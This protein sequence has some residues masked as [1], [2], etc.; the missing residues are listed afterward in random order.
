MHDQAH[1]ERELQTLLAAGKKIAAVKLYKERT[2]SSLMDAKNAVEELARSGALPPTPTTFVSMHTVGDE[3]LSA[4]VAALLGQ[5][6]KLQAIKLYKDRTGVRLMDA[7]RAV[8]S[9]QSSS[10]VD[11][12]IAAELLPS[13]RMGDMRE[14]VRLYQKRT[15]ADRRRSR[16][17]VAALAKQ[18]GMYDRESACLTQALLLL[19]GGGL[20]LAVGAAVMMVLKTLFPDV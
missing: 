16:R 20:L 15:G 10:A 4:E 9:L 7:K 12:R 14:A 6:Q 3:S 5:G 19:V 18:H 2:G 11:E 1:L 8:E 17:A 13:L